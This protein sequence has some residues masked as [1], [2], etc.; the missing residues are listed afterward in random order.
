M[1]SAV[2]ESVAAKSSILGKGRLKLHKGLSKAESAILIQSRTGRTSC[3]HFLNIRGVPGYESPVCTH[4]Y[5]GAETVEHILLHC[6]AER[7]RRQWRG[8][9]TITELLDSPDR[10][11]QVAKWLIQSGRFEH[12]R[13]ANQLQYE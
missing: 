8:G 12:F 5:T 7:A 1:R 11:Q 3:A 2:G 6:S 9:T 10:T 4:C 13:L